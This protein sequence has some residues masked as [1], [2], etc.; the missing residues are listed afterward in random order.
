MKALFDN[1][2]P[3]PCPSSFNFAAHVLRRADELPD[4][5]ALAV[6]AMSGSERWSFGRLKAAVLGT[7]TGLAQQGLQRGDVVLIRLGNTVDFPIAYLGAIAG[8]FVPAPTSSQLTAPEVAKIAPQV[9]P[10]LVLT[11]PGVA[12]PEDLG[13]PQIDL[14][15][16]R[17]FRDL[18]PA[19]YDMGDPNRLAYIL[20]TS[21]TSGKARPV[22]HA[23]RAIWARQMMWADWYDLQES[24][25]LLH[26]GAFNWSFTLG[27]GLM[28]PWTVGATALIPS[29]GTPLTALPLLLKRHDATILA[30]APGVYRKLLQD[31]PKMDLPKLRHGLTAGE[32]MPATVRREWEAATC[33]EV[34][35]AFGMSECST[36]I[37][38]SPGHPAHGSLGRPQQGRRI[39]IIGEDGPVKIGEEGLIA[40]SNRDPGL[41]L[42]YLGAEEETSARFQGEWFLTGDLG[43]MDKG[44]EIH[45]RGRA[46]DMMNAG[47]YRVSPLEVEAALSQFTDVKEI[48]VTDVEIKV[49]TRVIAA[50]YVADKDI[51]EDTL[52]AFA[53]ENLARYKQPRLYRRVEALPRGANNKLLRRKLT[54]EGS[55]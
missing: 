5:I 24:D 4:K 35:E 48:A 32:K 20:F 16:L 40:V 15:T 31:H 6:M 2:A 51:P 43:I 45:Y 55:Q 7:A 8:G 22:A 26:A 10:R 11:A 50:F 52:K 18:P 19:T 37:S 29:E 46:D 30:A 44:F 9:Q 3:P 33:C 14:K 54:L 17:S 49:D 27:T 21:G 41:M 39:A 42:G 36:F 12:C 1:G 23:H 34:H 28:D 47:G 38:G 13:C 25:R 53:E